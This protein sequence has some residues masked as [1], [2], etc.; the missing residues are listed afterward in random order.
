VLTEKLGW[1]WDRV[2]GIPEEYGWEKVECMFTG[3]RD[4]C[5]FIKRGFGRTTHLV[6]IDIREGRKQRE[7]A[8]ELIREYDGK[9]PASLDLFL[10][11]LGI[12][13]QEFEEI[14][15]QQCVAPYEHDPSSIEKA[16]PLWDQERWPDILGADALEN[17]QEKDEKAA[18]KSEA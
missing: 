18:E 4:Y 8:M 15:M 5:K 10:E 12:S 3:I 17:N 14:L 6:S 9:R 11:L 1:K 2:E 16:E 13:E 7:E